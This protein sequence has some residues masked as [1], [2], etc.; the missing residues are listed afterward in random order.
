MSTDVHT[1]DPD[2]TLLELKEHM[3]KEKHRGYPVLSG[4]EMIGVIT[5]SDLQRVAEKDHADTRVA[6]VMTRKLYVI[7]PSEEASAA[8]RMM[9]M[10]NICRL[11]VMEDGRLV[12]I[13]SREDLV[14]AIELCSG[15][16][17]KR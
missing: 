13:I 12:G 9:N 2:M 3:F 17:W 1:V 14:R 6:E 10:L 16:D 15:Q 7:A 5:L 8:M 4:E 11:P